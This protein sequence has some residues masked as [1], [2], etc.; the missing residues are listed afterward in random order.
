MSE[1]DYKRIF[2]KKLNFYMAKCGKTQNDLVH[3]F[4]YRAST[5]SDWC[6]GKK[7]LRMDKIQAL[8][9]Y[10]GVEKSDLIEDKPKNDKYYL[11]PETASIAE[12]IYNDPNLRVLFDAARDSSPENMRLA[13]EML[14]RMKD[15]NP[16]G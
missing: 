15:T 13:A 6:N 4:G 3:D 2:A 10:F 11:D 9:D 14:K 16:D 1:D 12:Q 5:V 8:A 7:L